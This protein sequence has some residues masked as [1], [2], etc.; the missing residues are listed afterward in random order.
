MDFQG[1]EN[2]MQWIHVLC[3]KGSNVT[4][5]LDVYLNLLQTW[6]GNKSYIHNIAHQR[7]TAVEH[8]L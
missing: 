6:V 1:T 3:V 5:Y 7:K 4:S 2:Q 8:D